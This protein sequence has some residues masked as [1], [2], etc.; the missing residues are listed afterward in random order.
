MNAIRSPLGA[1]RML[2]IQPEVLCRTRPIGNSSW[3]TPS[4]ARATA[5]RP[6]TD[7]SALMML[8]ST[9]NGDPPFIGTRD[10]VPPLIG[11]VPSVDNSASSPDCDTAT[12]RNSSNPSERDSGLYGFVRYRC[13]GSLSQLALYKIA[14]PSGANRAPPT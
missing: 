3:L 10:S 13:L 11:P 2:L 14:W 1:T 4:M 9:V 12:S 8:R 7:Q 6:S 5:S